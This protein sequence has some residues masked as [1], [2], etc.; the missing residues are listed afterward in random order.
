MLKSPCFRSGQPDA[1]AC[2]QD[3]H[4]DPPAGRW[5]QDLRGDQGEEA[6]C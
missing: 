2:L 6:L 3:S 5:D 1:E 4:G